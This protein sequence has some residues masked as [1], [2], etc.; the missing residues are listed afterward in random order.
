CL[1]VL[2]GSVSTYPLTCHRRFQS[3]TA[4]GHTKS[5]SRV[6]SLAASRL[7]GKK[8]TGTSSPRDLLFHNLRQN[9][10]RLHVKI[11][12]YPKIIYEKDGH[13]DVNYRYPGRPR[14]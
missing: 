11:M 14:S 5:N 12:P 7:S 10:L 8:Y 4:V 1:G 13:R 3:A 6:I 2:S 9:H